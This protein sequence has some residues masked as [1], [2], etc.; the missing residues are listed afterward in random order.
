MVEKVKDAFNPD[1]VVLQCGVDGLALDPCATWNW[2]VGI[3]PGDMGWCVRRVL[4]DW[5][6]KALLLGGGMLYRTAILAHCLG[7]QTLYG[8]GGYNSTNAARAW[9]HLTSIAVRLLLF[10]FLVRLVTGSL[11]IGKA[12]PL[13]T[14]IPDHAVFPLY[15][16]SFTLDVPAGNM[17]DENNEEYI[18]SIERCFSVVVDRIRTRMEL[19]NK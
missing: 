2:S 11:K 10:S 16:P 9:A 13:D 18:D 1:Y 19:A 15:G 6:C 4:N 14:P 8:I 7:T 3:E 17:R 5:G 12:L